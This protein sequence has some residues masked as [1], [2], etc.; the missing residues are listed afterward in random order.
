MTS[1]VPKHAPSG[2]VENLWDN[3]GV[4]AYAPRRF[5]NASRSNRCTSC[6]FFSS[7]P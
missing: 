1:T 6:S 5:M 2:T 7:A 3:L 4:I